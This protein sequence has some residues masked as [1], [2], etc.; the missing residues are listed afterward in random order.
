MKYNIKDVFGCS[1]RVPNN[2]PT[3]L[4]RKMHRDF[5]NALMS[6]NIVVVYGESRQGKTWTIE[7]YCPKQHRIGCVNDMTIDKLKI[8]ILDAIGIKY[9][10]YDYELSQTGGT[11]GA[12]RAVLSFGMANIGATGESSV[13][14]TETYKTTCATVDLDNI[15]QFVSVIKKKLKDEYIVLDNFHYLNPEVQRQFCSMLK[16]FNYENIKVIIIGVW[17]EASKITSL[18]PDLG[19]RCQHIDIG[20]WEKDELAE[21]AQKG[22][23]ALNINISEEILN[24]FISVSAGNIGI[25]KDVLGKFCYENGIERTQKTTVMLDDIKNAKELMKKHIMDEGYR[26]VKDRLKNLAKPARSRRESKKMRAKIVVSILTLLYE[27]NNVTSIREGIKFEDIINEINNICS[28]KNSASLQQSNIVQ[29]LGILHEREES[30]GIGGNYIP[31]FYYDKSNKKLLVLEPYLYVLKLVDAELLKSI[32]EE[33][34][35]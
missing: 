11:K 33:I 32:I 14:K 9:H 23:Q 13:S 16:E 6:K 3:F 21:V 20:M 30:K 2:C 25:F 31:L 35:Y 19:N 12:S 22:E 24:Y 34:E 15:T 7:R 5:K 4:E 17:K 28:V 1:E 18:A 29:E 26:P 8:A 27:A 10:D